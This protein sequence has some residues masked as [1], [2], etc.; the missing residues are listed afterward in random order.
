MAAPAYGTDLTTITTAETITGWSALGGGASGLVQ[1]TDFFIQGTFSVSKQ[2]SSALKGQ[3]FNNG[4]TIT[5]GAN[6]H[7]FVWLYATTPGAINTLANGGMRVT[8]GTSLTAFNDFHVEG[9]ETYAYG[10]WNCYPIRYV[11]TGNASAP[12]R[13]LTG[14]PGANPQYFGGQMNASAAVKAANFGVDVIRYGT[15]IFITAGEVG[16]AGTFGG[17]AAQN[18]SNA[19]RW[20]ILQAIAGGYALQGRFVIGQ[21]TAGTA[22]AA[23]FESSNTLITIIDTPHTLTDFTQIIIDHA[24]TVCNFTNITF[25]SLGTNN[26]GKLVYNNASTVSAISGCVFDG[27]GTTT[28]RA[29]VAA[30][31]TTWR[32]S[33][34]I[35]PNG[36]AITDSDIISSTDSTGAI[37]I[38]SPS[39]MAVLERI[40][41]TNNAKA[42][43]I[44]AAGTYDFNGHQFSGNTVMVDFTGAGTCT[45]VPSNGSNI[46]QAGCTASGGGTI[47]VNSPAVTLTLTGIAA[48]SEVRVIR[49]SDTTELGGQETVNTGSYVFT[50]SLGGTVVDIYIINNAYQWYSI[51]SYTLANE[52][53]SIPVSQ[54]PDRQYANP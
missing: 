16:N 18:D 41:F 31:G 15:G 4:S 46:A 5:P 32:D 26:K 48:N 23:R 7:F 9:S 43:K 14:S 24:S 36:A 35:T 53:A 6:T 30:S 28:L 1:E 40:N 12:Y 39:E 20:G 10:G 19:N 27:F 17:A 47:T 25:L 44:T 3:V 2:V 50:H 11:T 42:I 22:T 52:N 54:I 29:A 38:N 45:I 8:I 34:S 51:R 33:E 49:I 37:T 21:N 13:T